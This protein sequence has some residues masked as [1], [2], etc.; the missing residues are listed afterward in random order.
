MSDSVYNLVET[1]TADLRKDLEHMRRLKGNM[2][3]SNGPSARRFQ[4]ITQD[5]DDIVEE[6]KR[7]GVSFV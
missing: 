3:V 4:D 2:R 7:R 1:P 6:L 5:I